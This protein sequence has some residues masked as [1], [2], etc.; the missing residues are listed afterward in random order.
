MH[1]TVAS[2]GMER[3]TPQRGEKR[4]EPCPVMYILTG[5]FHPE[6]ERTKNPMEN[7]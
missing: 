6:G 5:T 3:N 1:N 2:V 7:L 4:T